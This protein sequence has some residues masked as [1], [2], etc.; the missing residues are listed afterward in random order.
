VAPHGPGSDVTGHLK[1]DLTRWNQA[2]FDRMR[3]RVSQHKPVGVREHSAIRARMRCTGG[4]S[5]VQFREQS[6]AS[7]GSALPASYSERPGDPGHQEE[8]VHPVIDA[9]NDLDNVLYEIA[10]EPSAVRHSV[11]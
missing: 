10:N 11:Q 2:Y 3:Q 5:S 4:Y 9:M 8:Y 7:A 6:T 1:F